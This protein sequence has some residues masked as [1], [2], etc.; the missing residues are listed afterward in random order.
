[1]TVTRVFA[2]TGSIVLRCRSS[3]VANARMTK[4][5]LAIAGEDIAVITQLNPVRTP[6]SSTKEVLVVGDECIGQYRRHLGEWARRGWRLDLRALKANAGDVACAI[7]S[8]ARRTEKNWVLDAAPLVPAG[9]GAAVGAASAAT[10]DRR[11]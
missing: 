3:D 11:D 2:A 10:L 4:I 9:V 5:N 7:P 6:E 8:P 1:M